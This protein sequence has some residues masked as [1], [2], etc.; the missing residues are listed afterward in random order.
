MIDE[1]R[2]SSSEESSASSDDDDDDSSCVDTVVGES[3]FLSRDVVE[4][5]F[6]LG[7]VA[8]ENRSLPLISSIVSSS[9]PSKD[10][11]RS[12]SSV[13]LDHTEALERGR[14]RRI[15][16]GEQQGLFGFVNRERLVDMTERWDPNARLGDAR[17]MLPPRIAGG[18]SPFRYR[19]HGF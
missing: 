1:S 8:A 11:T 13:G 6:L 14:R 15:H 9:S 17:G 5:V 18:I 10:E 4:S 19:L 2:E 16:G 7:V 12:T 3:R